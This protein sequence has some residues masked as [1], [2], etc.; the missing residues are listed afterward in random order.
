MG[1]GTVKLRKVEAGHID[2]ILGLGVLT[3]HS[4][5]DMLCKCDVQLTF[6]M[7]ARDTPERA[8]SGF[9]VIAS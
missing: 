9:S 6:L 2:L 3:N 8:S 4:E 5:Y 1:D 7:A